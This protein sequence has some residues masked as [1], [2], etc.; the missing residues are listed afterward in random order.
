MFKVEYR[1]A[2]GQV[3]TEMIKDQTKLIAF[4]EALD[5]LGCYIISVNTIGARRPKAF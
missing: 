5:E 4:V 2:S 3:V 1:N